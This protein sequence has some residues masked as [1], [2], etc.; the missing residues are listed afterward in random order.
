MFGLAYARFVLL[1]VLGLL[2]LGGMLAWLGVV[3]VRTW[4]TVRDFSRQVSAA[5][6]RV[7]LATAE[8]EAVMALQ[9]NR[10]STAGERFEW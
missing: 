8:L 3:S 10:P 1:V 6:E 4:R 9:A 5:G 7:S 2:I